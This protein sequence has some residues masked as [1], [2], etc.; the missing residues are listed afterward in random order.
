MVNTTDERFMTSNAASALTFVC[1]HNKAWPYWSGLQQ[2]K[3]HRILKQTYLL[4]SV[5]C[6]SSHSTSDPQCFHIAGRR[7]YQQLAPRPELTK[8]TRRIDKEWW[9]QA[10]TR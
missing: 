5:A 9:I 10:A 8:D 1:E 6:C 4:W 2:H 7:N 3:S